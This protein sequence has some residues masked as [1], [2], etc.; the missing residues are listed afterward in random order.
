MSAHAAHPRPHGRPRPGLCERPPPRHAT[1]W[2]ASTP[3]RC[4]LTVVPRGPGFR[5]RNRGGRSR[6]ARARPPRRHLAPRSAAGAGERAV[7]RE[8][9]TTRLTALCGTEAATQAPGRGLVTGWPIEAPQTCLCRGSWQGAGGGAGS[10]THTRP[11]L[12]RGS[13]PGKLG[14]G[15]WARATLFGRKSPPGHGGSVWIRALTARR[16]RGRSGRRFWNRVSPR[17]PFHVEGCCGEQRVPGDP[18]AACGLPG[19]SSRPGPG[20]PTGVASR[21][22][23]GGGVATGSHF[24]HFTPVWR[25]PRSNRRGRPEGERLLRAREQGSQG[26]AR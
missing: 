9:G 23:G 20:A 13:S 16:K 6:R 17:P 25:G 19:A 22:A 5:P 11:A 4:L 10:L 21:E 15:A 1:G 24:S 12:A 18:T 2:S 26:A 3:A 8:H 7:W 14:P